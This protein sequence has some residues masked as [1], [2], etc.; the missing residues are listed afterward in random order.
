MKEY[1]RLV[2]T[3]FVITFV[4]AAL[5]G[6]TNALT[7]DRIAAAA[8][9]KQNNAMRALLPEAESF[10]QFNG[11]DDIYIGVNSNGETVGYCINASSPGYGGNVEM[12]VGMDSEL[13][14]SGIEILSNSETAGLG[15]NCTKPEF[16]AQFA[17]LQAPI[18]VSKGNANGVNQINAITGATI[19]SNA[20]A[21]GVNSA[22]ES[23][24]SA[25]NNIV[26][27]GDE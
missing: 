3:L 11:K 24:K 21:S 23:L 2:V 5:L 10:D 20:V 13:K 14:L 17:G 4:A 9:E 1:I 6:A 12:M 8:L 25:I 19:T 27:G 26:E 16:K 15:A 7:E 18:S 22:Y